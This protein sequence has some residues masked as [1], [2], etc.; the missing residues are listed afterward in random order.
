MFNSD[1][2][3]NCI[4][5][6]KI[7]LAFIL[8]LVGQS[9]VAAGSYT[10]SV[11]G[12]EVTDTNTGL[13]WRRCS[14]GQIWSVNACTGTA[15]QYTHQEAFERAANQTGWRLPNIKELSS[16]TNRVFPKNPAIDA[17]AFPG[18]LPLYYWSSSPFAGNASDAW[19]VLFS[20]GFVSVTN[21]ANPI[22]VRLVR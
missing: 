17:A 13:V 16:L 15:I 22:Y 1:R 8:V 14:E 18:T 12:S 10:Y 4:N 6:L 21:R 5:L 20:G 11:D 3:K 2:L 9:V 7:S 19:Y